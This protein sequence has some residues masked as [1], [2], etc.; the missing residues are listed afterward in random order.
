MFCQ[1]GLS[2]ALSWETPKRTVIAKG[3]HA[4]QGQQ[5]NIPPL[6]VHWLHFKTAVLQP[7]HSLAKFLQIHT[8]Y[9]HTMCASTLA[10]GIK[11]KATV[12]NPGWKRE[13]PLMD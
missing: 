10:Q 8:I 11:G 13:S 1:K 2:S 3:M 5:K 6:Q 9:V 12:V 4:G 7:K